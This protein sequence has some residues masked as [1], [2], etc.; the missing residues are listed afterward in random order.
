M[1]YEAIARRWARAIFDLGKE[2]GKLADVNRDI[3]SFADLTFLLLPR[4]AGMAEKAW[5]PPRGATWAGHRERLAAHSRLWTQ[6]DL[7]YFQSSTVDWAT[8]P[9]RLQATR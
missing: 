9:P 5:G 1:S 8:A 7:M 2:S 4:L 3:A 6:D